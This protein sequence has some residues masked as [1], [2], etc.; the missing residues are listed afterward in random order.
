RA[1]CAV[2]ARLRRLGSDAL[3]TAQTLLVTG[4]A[5]FI[6][7]ALVRQLIAETD[8]QVIN[9]DALTYAGNLDSLAEARHDRRHVFAQV[10]ICDAD[11]LRTLFDEH[12]PDAVV[13][14]AA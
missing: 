2:C 1:A 3:V 4:G 9:V 13:H 6:G 10:D 7:S 14:L 5:G 12:T 8:S 11:A